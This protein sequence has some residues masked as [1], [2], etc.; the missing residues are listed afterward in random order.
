MMSFINL[1]D[2][3]QGMEYSNKALFSPTDHNIDVEALAFI[4]SL[5]LRTQVTFKVLK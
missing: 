3:W 2:D 5:R 4:N 1:S